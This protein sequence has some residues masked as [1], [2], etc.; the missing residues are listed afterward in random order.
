MNKT[1]SL[2]AKLLSAFGVTTLGMMAVGFIGLYTLSSVTDDFKHI[3]HENMTNTENLMQ[4]RSAAKDLTRVVYSLFLPKEHAFDEKIFDKDYKEAV[5][6][7]EEAQTQYLS[8]PLSDEKEKNLFEAQR[9]LWKE[10]VAL[11]EECVKLGKSYDAASREAFFKK[12]KDEFRPAGSKHTRALHELI[13]YQDEDNKVWLAR[14]DEA[15]RIGTRNSLVTIAVGSVCFILIAL[16]LASRLTQ[17][18]AN[19]LHQLESGASYVAR[20]AIEIAATSEQFSGTSTQQA[21]AVQ[22]TAASLH[23]MSSMVEKNSENAESSMRSTEE[24]DKTGRQAQAAVQQMN[25]AIIEIN[26]SNENTAKHLN[27][28]T[29]RIGEIV[30]LIREIG[31]KTKVINDIVFQ[32]KLLS[33]NA[34]VEA[35]RAGEHGRGFAVVAEEVGNL[36]RMSG[37]AAKEIREMLDE[38]ISLVEGIVKETQGTMSKLVQFGKGKVDAGL[39]ASQYC[40]EALDA[41]LVTVKSVSERVREI[42]TAS[43]EQAG[44]IRQISGAVTQLDQAAQENMSSA[45]QSAGSATALKQ[46]AEHLEEIV[47]GLTAII[48]G[49]NGTRS[50]VS[51]EA[52]TDGNDQRND[53]DH[54]LA[55]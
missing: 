37:S 26:T 44:G 54:N 16:F 31:D 15:A 45:Q 6:R 22:E 7:F 24:S 40:G 42:S 29:E 10:E 32:T 30:K 19:V 8:V 12:A 47:S 21:A 25:N 13:D 50:A 28:S 46:Q 33:F 41:L 2:K 43:Q 17:Q 39:S 14:A 52:L 18:L 1:F 36:A 35:A 3:T 48:N 20:A 51:G 49:Q 4:M 34:S 27:E 5:T 55:A 23:E 11:A 38:S 53:D 9:K